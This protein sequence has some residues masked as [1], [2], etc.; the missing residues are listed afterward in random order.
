MGKIIKNIDKV[1]SVTSDGENVDFGPKIRVAGNLIMPDKFRDKDFVNVPAV[2]VEVEKKEKKVEVLKNFKRWTTSHIRRIGLLILNFFF[3]YDWV[4]AVVGKFNHWFS[5][6]NSV[7]V[8]YPATEKYALAYVYRRHW[9]KMQWLPRPVG[10][11]KQDG[12]WGLMTVISSTEKDFCSIENVENLKVL[13]ERTERIR[14]LLN[15]KQKTFAG[16]LPGVFFTKRLIR[17]TIEADVTV[18]V[19]MRAEEKVREIEKYP[20]EIPLIILGGKGFIGRRLIKRLSKTKRDIYCID[21]N[22]S[23]ANANFKDWP[24]NIRQKKAAILINLTR[25]A[26]LSYYVNLFW[27][28]LVLLNEVYPEPTEKELEILNKIGSSAYHIVG[29]KAKSFPSF[30][31]IYKGGIP[32]CA[33]WSSGN[34]DVII[35]K[36]N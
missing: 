12:K 23:G 22:N 34:I 31:K 2:E 27:P 32:C 10:I 3:N 19:V 36:I 16:I 1:D 4:F 7:F 14:Q 8:A 11:F 17:E 21:V 28:G 26:V 6:L 9:R 33:A 35:K 15:A 24:N 5:F 13:V 20:K 29:V 30:P 25:K 18:E